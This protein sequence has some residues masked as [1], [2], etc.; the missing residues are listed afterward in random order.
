MDTTT[1]QAAIIGELLDDFTSSL[2][3]DVALR[4][5]GLK[6]SAAMQQKMSE[7]AQK[8]NEGELTESEQAEYEAYVQ[9]GSFL[10]VVKAKASQSVGF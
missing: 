7:L 5:A 10:D 2:T 1:Q 9:A 8:C 4:L 6:A 3:P